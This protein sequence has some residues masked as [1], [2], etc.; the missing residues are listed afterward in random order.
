MSVGNDV[1]DLADPET[2]LGG[3]HPRFAA[4]VFSAGERELLEASRSGP[5]LPWALWAAKESAY[6]ALKRLAPETVFSPKEFE[7]GLS[8]LPPEGAG[9]VAAGWVVH[10]GRRFDLEVHLDGASVHAVARIGEAPAGAGVLWK[11]GRAVGDP[12]VAVR[13]LA[14]TAIGSALGLDPAGLRIVR[15]PPVATHPDGRLAADVSLSH[16]GRFVAFACTLAGQRAGRVTSACC[17]GAP[18]S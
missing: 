2:R 5:A 4:R 11:V 7:V 3:L 14:A 12:G 17:P 16:H 10:R 15:R 9:G 8:P 1:V 6:K 18:G 13:R